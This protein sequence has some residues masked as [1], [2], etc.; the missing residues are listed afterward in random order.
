MCEK[1]IMPS[2]EKV[3]EVNRNGHLH[4]TINQWI[5]VKA[6]AQY[7]GVYGYCEFCNEG[8]ATIYDEPNAKVG[9]QLWYLHP[10]K[11]CSRG[12]YIEHVE[13]EDLPEVFAYLKEANERNIER[14]SKLV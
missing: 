5:C 3:N 2:A 6:R 13:Q 4:D 7:L 8:D 14:F 10:R 1:P 11:G 9:L 12:V